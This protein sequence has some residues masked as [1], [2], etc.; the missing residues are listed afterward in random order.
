MEETTQMMA[1]LRD[2]MEDIA[3]VQSVGF[4]KHN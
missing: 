4:K 1:D 2:M 3:K